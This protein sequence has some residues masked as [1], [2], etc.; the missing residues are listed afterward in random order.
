LSIHIHYYLE[1]WNSYRSVYS[2]N[3][4]KYKQ[5]H[6]RCGQSWEWGSDRIQVESVILNSSAGTSWVCA[7]Q[8]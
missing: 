8:Q 6:T 1:S 2:P 7:P 4:K 5:C 3:Q